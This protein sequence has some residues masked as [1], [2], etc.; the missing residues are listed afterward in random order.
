MFGQPEV[1]GSVPQLPAVLSGYTERIANEEM[2]GGTFQKLIGSPGSPEVVREEPSIQF[3]GSCEGSP[4]KGWTQGLVTLPNGTAATLLDVLLRL[5]TALSGM[6]SGCLISVS[7]KVLSIQYM[8]R[9]YTE[10]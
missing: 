1:T 2:L 4:V 7:P 5:H 9:K 6:L 8:L 3:K 10:L